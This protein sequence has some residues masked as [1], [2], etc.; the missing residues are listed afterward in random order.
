MEGVVE[1]VEGWWISWGGG[2]DHGG[3]MELVEG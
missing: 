2:G 1:L 3:M